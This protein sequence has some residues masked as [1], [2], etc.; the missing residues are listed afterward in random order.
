MTARRALFYCV[1]G[2]SAYVLT[3]LAILPATWLSAGLERV[4]GHRLSMRDPSGTVWRGSARL[5]GRSSHGVW[6]DLGQL[7]WSTKP[8]QLLVGRLAMQIGVGAKP[9]ARVELTFGSVT[10]E[11][12]DVELPGS[13]LASVAPAA[14]TVQPDGRIRIRSDRF[15]M[16]SSSLF[17]TADVEWR[18]LRVRKPVPLDLGSHAAEL[19]G[20]GKSIDIELHSISGPLKVSGTGSWSPGQGLSISGRATPVESAPAM[21]TAFLKGMCAEYQDP[22]CVFR[23]RY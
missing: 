20:S 12:L 15:R 13:L 11:G 16:D 9:D 18:D 1:V 14:D 10:V 17:G 8:S 23:L 22:T 2:L 21:L 19:R 7:H 5:V 3:L 4:S 6:V